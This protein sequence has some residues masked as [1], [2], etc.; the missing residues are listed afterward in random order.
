MTA[1]LATSDRFCLLPGGN[2]VCYRTS[3]DPAGQPVILIAGLTLDLTSWPP[4][5]VEGLVT[6][7]FFVIRLDNRDVG[8]STWATSKPPGRLRQLLRRP[9]RDGYDLAD[10]AADTVGLLDHLGIERAHLVGMSM[11]GMIAQTVAARFPQRVHSLTSI[12]STTGASNVGQPSVATLRLLTRPGSR[13]R[14][15]FVTRHVQLMRHLAGLRYPT[16]EPAAA[17]YAA[18]AWERGPG[19]AAAQGVARQINAILR[20]GDRTCELHRISAPTL[21]IHGDRDL[22]V[23]PSGGR[24]TAEAIPGARHLTVAGMGHDLAPGVIDRLVGLITENAG[25]AQPGRSSSR[26]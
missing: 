15:Q 7:G 25:A 16:H 10:L 6:R 22:I 2:R 20:S 4:A 8:R 24:A 14:E 3:G 26:D 17:E 21:V 9:R 19:P 11:G 12:F 13:T 5:M 23:H 1:A 18:G